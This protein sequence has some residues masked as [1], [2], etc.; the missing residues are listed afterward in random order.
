MVAFGGWWLVFVWSTE[1]LAGWLE[2]HLGK[3]KVNLTV[4]YLLG[5]WAALREHKHICSKKFN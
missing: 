4:L 1:F 3:V 5:C 2:V